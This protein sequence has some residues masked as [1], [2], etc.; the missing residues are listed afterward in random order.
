VLQ[1]PSDFGHQ[2]ITHKIK[3]IIIFIKNGYGTYR[4]TKIHVILSKCNNMIEKHSNTHVTMSLCLKFWTNVKNKY[5][6]KMFDHFFNFK[7]IKF[8]KNKMKIM[9]RHFLIQFGK[10]VSMFR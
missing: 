7:V 9:L 2:S 10:K 6:K 4:T 8:A 3:Y 1:A 5:E